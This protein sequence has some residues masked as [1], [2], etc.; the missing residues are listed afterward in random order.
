MAPEHRKFDEKA[1]LVMICA[2]QEVPSWT[3]VRALFHSDGELS[4]KGQWLYSR[5]LIGLR[6][7]Q[8]TV[9]SEATPCLGFVIFSIHKGKTKFAVM[10]RF[11]KMHHYKSRE[12]RK[13]HKVSFFFRKKISKQ[14][15]VRSKRILKKGEAW[16]KINQ[17]LVFS[18]PTLLVAHT[19]LMHIG[20]RSRHQRPISEPFHKWF[21]KVF[22]PLSCM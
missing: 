13:K 3:I 2:L 6:P 14:N 10:L 5:R 12:N 21:F 9:D 16:R 15:V 18:H 19:T 17:M 8:R 1:G 20:I 7:L 22:A 4:R 11:L